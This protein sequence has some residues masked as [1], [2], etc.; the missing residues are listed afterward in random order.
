MS[1]ILIATHGNFASGIAKSIEL[2]TGETANITAID[3]YVDDNDLDK[4]LNNYIQTVN[5]QDNI[6]VFT[7]IYG[8]S[9]NQK[10]MITFQKNNISARIITGFNLPLLLEITTTK[11]LLSDDELDQII[12]QSR[13]ELKRCSLKAI[14]KTDDSEDFF[15]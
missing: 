9:V 3:A 2:L 1:K 10:I 8:G 5:P 4:E 14:T 15:N 11:K 7:D 6:Y 12:S 13:A